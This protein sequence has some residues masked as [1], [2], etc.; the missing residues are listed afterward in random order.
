MSLSFYTIPNSNC[1]IRFKFQIISYSSAVAVVALAAVVV[2]VVV[3]G[4]S[5][6]ASSFILSNVYI[7]MQS[8]EEENEKEIAR[9]GH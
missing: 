9:R 2:D 4:V 1:T 6:S 5:I 7:A 8:V 3:V